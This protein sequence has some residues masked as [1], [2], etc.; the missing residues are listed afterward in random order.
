[1][2]KNGSGKTT[3]IKCLME[4]ESF[5]GEIS[6]NGKSIDSVRNEC[7]VLWDDCPFYNSLS[8]LKNLLIFSEDKKTKDEIIKIAM[9]FLD[10]DLLNRK[11]STYSYG[12]KKKLALCLVDILEPTYLIMD[13][14]S[15]GLDY[16][17]MRFLKKRIIEWKVNKTILVTGHQFE[18]YNDIID[19]LL[20]F[21]G[22]SH[23][24][25]D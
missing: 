16:E 14:I 18:F 2:G 12:Q 5:S 13:E 23:Y 3:L 19:E 7:L 15:N 6:F 17:T 4:M 9:N 11:V 25:S 22:K 10:K 24:S 21:K 1:M 8:G 20:I